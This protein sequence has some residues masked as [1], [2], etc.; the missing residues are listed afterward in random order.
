MLS[1]GDS[2]VQLR[3]WRVPARNLPVALT[4]MATQR[5]TVR[6][7]DGVNF[8]KLLG[9]GSGAT[10]TT[11]D[12]DLGHW[13]MLTVFDSVLAAQRF[14]GSA[15]VRHWGR[16]ATE[17]IR[18]DLRPLSSKGSWAGHD[19][20]QV[21]QPPARWGGPVAALTRAR[22]KPQLWRRFW[23]SVPPVA[24]DLRR[25][26]GVLM[27]LGI[28][29]APIGLQGTFSVWESNRALTEFAQ[30]GAAH[31]AAITDTAR[32]DWYSEEL[33]ARFAVTGSE[34]SFDGVTLPSA[35][36]EPTAAA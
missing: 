16:I 20:F 4:H 24:S 5:R 17:S 18:I 25:R 30:R 35:P 22:I 29:E 28:G 3:V 13:A 12:A 32:L 34:G 31:R 9:T 10:F 27:S 11:R 19:P 21:D 1:M 33:F 6:R 14:S 8:A 7:T 15:P 23:A 2:L 26:R 36:G